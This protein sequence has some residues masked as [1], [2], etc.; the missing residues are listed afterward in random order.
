MSFVCSNI[1]IVVRVCFLT[2]AHLHTFTIFD[3]DVIGT[4]AMRYCSL[5]VLASMLD[6]LLPT[7]SVI[8]PL[9]YPRQRVDP[10]DICIKKLNFPS[11]ETRLTVS[12]SRVAF[13][14]VA[15]VLYFLKF[16]IESRRDDLSRC[17]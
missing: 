9:P 12:D 15:R 5:P 10:L 13:C 17:I 6:G 11:T 8:K 3:D 7:M 1:S 14:F 16:L 4:V 2:R